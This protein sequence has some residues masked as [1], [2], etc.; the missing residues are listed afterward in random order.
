[1]VECH[2]KTA[3]EYL[4]GHF[5]ILQSWDERLPIFLLVYTALIHKIIGSN[6]TIM[7][8]GRELCLSWDLLFGDLLDKEQ[9][10]TNYLVDFIDL[11][12]DIYYCIH[13][14]LKLASDQEAH[15]DCLATSM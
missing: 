10:T 7:V 12:H 6:S 1:M 15:H 8:F 13:Q 5:N 11:L 14:Y 4:R 9:S 2:V 3:Q